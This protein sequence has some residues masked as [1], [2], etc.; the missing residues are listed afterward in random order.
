MFIKELSI[1]YWWNLW[2]LQTPGFTPC[3]LGLFYEY[4]E[5][6]LAGTLPN[7]QDKH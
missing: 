7:P 5:P 6:Y 2:D 1:E 3:A 4:P